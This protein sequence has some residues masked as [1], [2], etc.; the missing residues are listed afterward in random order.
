M[1]ITVVTN[2]YFPAQVF[3][4]RNGAC[5]VQD[6]IV[7]NAAANNL[8]CV[9]AVSGKVIEVL[10]LIAQ[11][12]AVTY[13]RCAFKSASAGTVVCYIHAAQN[14]LAPTLLPFNQAGWFRT[15]AGQGLYVDFVHQLSFV[16]GTYIAYT[17]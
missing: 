11:S 6:F 7:G 1:S 3:R 17:P 12:D 9:A 8:L 10:S 4:D 16:S 13:S 2:E 15:I 14:T 5:A